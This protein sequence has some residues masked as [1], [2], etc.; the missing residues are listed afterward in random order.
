VTGSPFR[1]NRPIHPTVGV[2][3]GEVIDGHNGVSILIQSGEEILHPWQWAFRCEAIGFELRVLL[4]AM[5]RAGSSDAFYEI[6]AIRALETLVA[7]SDELSTA[8]SRDF[9][10]T[11]RFSLVPWPARG[12]DVC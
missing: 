10:K 5:A 7:V 3:T 9:A 4:D 1:P 12:H 2:F 8:L 6:R 11:A